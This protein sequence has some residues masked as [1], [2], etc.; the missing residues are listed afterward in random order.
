MEQHQGLAGTGTTLHQVIAELTDPAADSQLFRGQ[1]HQG[2]LVIISGPGVEGEPL[3]VGQVVF[4]EPEFFKLPVKL[5]LLLPDI[6]EVLPELVLL[7]MLLLEFQLHG[8]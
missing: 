2:T 7:I 3:H 5:L 1:S 4:L 6:E 8:M